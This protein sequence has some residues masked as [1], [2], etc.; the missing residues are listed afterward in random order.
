M[1]H[2][3]HQSSDGAHVTEVFSTSIPVQHIYR[4]KAVRAA[5]LMVVLA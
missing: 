3:P 5:C 4:G 1:M 2:S